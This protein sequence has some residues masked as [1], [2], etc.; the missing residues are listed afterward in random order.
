MSVRINRGE[1]VL[2]VGRIYCDVIFTGLDRMPVLGEEH[3]ASGVSLHTGGGAYITAAFLASQ[4]RPVSLFATLPSGHFGTVV[5]D[6]LLQSGINSA[7][8]VESKTP[9]DPQLTVALSMKSERAFVTKR[10]G[11]ALPTQKINWQNFP[12]IGHLH[13]GELATLLEHPTLVAD[14]QE[15]GVTVSVDC[16]WDDAVFARDDLDKHLQGIDVFL[17][18]KS[19]FDR[20]KSVCSC[21]DSLPLCVVKQGA[22]GASAFCSTKVVS[23]PAEDVDV[24][25]TT[26]AG[27]AFN[28]GFIHGWMS[29]QGIEECLVLG[30]RCGATAVR[31]VGGGAVARAVG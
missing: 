4:K 30:N 16:S 6:E 27:D 26:G 5:R 22:A 13:I 7:H 11:D 23:S 20:L 19:E 24:I 15:A 12:G 28:A 1:A 18:N 17:P 14:A 8:C 29:G 9:I 10:S 3:F 25:D 31:S 21:I 2:C